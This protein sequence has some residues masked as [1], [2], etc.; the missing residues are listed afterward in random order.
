MAVSP[1]PAISHRSTVIV[2]SRD[3]YMY[4]ELCDTI[5]LTH[6]HIT[7]LLTQ[8][9]QAMHGSKE[10]FLSQVITLP[11]FHTV[12]AEE[13]ILADQARLAYLKTRWAEVALS[14]YMKASNLNMF[15][16][17]PHDETMFDYFVATITAEASILIHSNAYD[18][19]D[20]QFNGIMGFVSL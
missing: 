11:N 5:K 18:H 12:F 6:F 20:P 10:H 3:E 19:V 17:N 13:E 4:L 1:L 9:W 15:Q 8:V 2:D 16:S 14:L 7:E